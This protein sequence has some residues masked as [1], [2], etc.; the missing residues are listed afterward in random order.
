MWGWLVSLLK[1]KK[2]KRATLIDAVSDNQTGSYVDVEDWIDI[3]IQINLTGSL[4]PTVTI[5]GTMDTPD[6]PAQ[7]IKWSTLYTGTPGSAIV[8]LSGYALNGLR[9]RTGSVVGSTTARILASG[10]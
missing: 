5:E 8:S 3:T 1:G 10:R 6:T 4:L 7:S 2:M 9:A